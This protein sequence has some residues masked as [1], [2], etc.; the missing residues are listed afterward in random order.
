M[1]HKRKKISI[2]GSGFVG[3]SCAQ[4][5]LSKSLADI[6][7]I[8]VNAG[9]A[10]G[11]ALD[12]LQAAASM[13]SALAIKGGADFSLTEDSDIVIITAGSP[14]KPGMDRKDLLLKNASIMQFVTKA[15]KEHCPDAFFIVVSNPLDAMAFLAHQI[16]ELP[17]QKILGMA[18]ILDT[19]RFKAFITER[20][21]CSPQDISALVL[22]GHGDRM[23]PLIRYSSVGAI[24]LHL[25]M[26]QKA[27]EELIERTQKGGGEIVSLLKTGSAHY[28]PALSA[29]EM[30]ESVLKDQKRVL[31]CS[32]LLEGEYKEEGVFIGVPCVLGEKGLEKIIELPLTSEE[33]TAFKK[34]VDGTRQLIE[35]M[36][37]LL[38]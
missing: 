7:L 28:A 14:R 38:N 2:I 33:Q 11:R 1:T 24:P 16:L 22:G 19:A 32:A 36:K 34:S 26:D 21:N 6:C 27:C 23:V 15:L 37:G 30:A 29:V 10:K 4:W 20:L 12:L 18:G 9:V 35:E 3:S 5:I 13:G 31:P 25:M 8:D 17:R